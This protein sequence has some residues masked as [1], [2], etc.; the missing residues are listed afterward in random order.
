MPRFVFAGLPSHLFVRLLVFVSLLVSTASFTPSACAADL[1][2]VHAKIYLSPAA[3]PI[4]D[5]TILIHNGKIR[6][7]GPSARTK[8]LRILRRTTVIDC[9][10]KVITAGFWNSH[11]HILTPTLLHSE[12]RSNEVISSELDRMFTRWGFT[13]VFDL[14]SILD[15]TN[16]IRRR[17][18]RGEVRGP[19]ILTVGDPFFPKNGTPVYVQ[20]LWRELHLPSEEIESIPQALNREKHQLAAGADGVKLFT[21]AIVADAILPMPLDAA[22]A[23]TA[24]AHRAGKPVFAHPSNTEGLEIALDSGVDILAHTAPGSG[25]WTPEFIA[26][27][28]SAHMALIPTLKLFDVEGERAHLSEAVRKPFID[29]A[30]SQL[31]AYHQAGGLILFGTDAGYIHDY[32]TTEEFRLMAE[33]GMTFPQ[34]LASLTTSPADRFGYARRCGR[35][36]KGMDADLVVL[37]AD[38]AK[39]IPAFAQIDRVIRAG[40]TVYPTY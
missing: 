8:P 27:L 15:N 26:R 39:N 33:A 34:I 11:V 21:G 29:S 3:P 35:I 5:G 17:V 24:G 38:P 2:L 14:A 37:S 13:T 16:N 6:A 22:K 28:K 10:G 19:R 7:V 9:R 36:A 18:A 25:D 20:Q 4:E 12:S 32:D 31:R 30:V 23:L 1:A 40:K